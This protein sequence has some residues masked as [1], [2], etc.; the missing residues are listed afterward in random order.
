MP[1]PAALLMERYLRLYCLYKSIRIINGTMYNLMYLKSTLYYH[2]IAHSM[3]VI[4]N[5]SYAQHKHKTRIQGFLTLQDVT[6][7]LSRNVGKKLPLL[8]VY[9]PEEHGSKK[10]CSL[11]EHVHTFMIRYCWILPIMRGISDKNCRENQNTHFNFNFFFFF[12][13][14]MPFM[15]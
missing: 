2:T 6:D 5:Q 8:A 3:A 4:S 9:Y 12:A 13:K 7:R 1:K 15:R 14:S 11:H 10:K